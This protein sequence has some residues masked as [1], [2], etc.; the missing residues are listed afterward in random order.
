MIERVINLHGVVVV[1]THEVLVVK[2]GTGADE[3]GEGEAEVIEL[4]LLEEGRVVARFGGT[5]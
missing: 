1:T 4:M 3:D 2:A 5:E